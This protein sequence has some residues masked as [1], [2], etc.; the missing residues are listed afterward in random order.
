MGF[1]LDLPHFLRYQQR[2]QEICSLSSNSATEGELTVNKFEVGEFTYE[3]RFE[4]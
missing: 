3:N 2:G 4:I 1:C